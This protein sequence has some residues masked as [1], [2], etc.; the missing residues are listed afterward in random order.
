MLQDLSPVFIEDSDSDCELFAQILSDDT[1]GLSTKARLLMG[2]KEDL[3][4]YKSHPEQLA[5]NQKDEPIQVPGDK[6]GPSIPFTVYDMENLLNALYGYRCLAE[7][8]EMFNGVYPDHRIIFGLGHLNDLI[9]DL[10]PL[11]DID[12][13]NDDEENEKFT[14]VMEDPDLSLYGKA[15]ILMGR[16]S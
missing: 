11:F 7:V 12:Y 15:R 10:S 3:D 14:F 2:I 8:L 13:D 4:I 6:S 1:L 16:S 5:G 9:E